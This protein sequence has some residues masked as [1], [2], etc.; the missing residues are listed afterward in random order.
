VPGREPG[1]AEGD[2]VDWEAYLAGLI[3]EERPR[4]EALAKEYGQEAASRR[5]RYHPASSLDELEDALRRESQRV[6]TQ[7][8]GLYES[9]DVNQPPTDWII[10][11]PEGIRREADGTLVIHT[12]VTGPNGATGFFERGFYAA[13]NRIELR[14]AFLRMDGMTRGLPHWVTGT[15]IEM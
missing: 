1:Q 7:V 2:W 6:R 8:P 13:D 11:N 3:A 5:V 4:A 10:Q 14:Q 9:I 12:D 15:E